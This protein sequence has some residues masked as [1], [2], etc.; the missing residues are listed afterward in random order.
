MKQFRN[1]STEIWKHLL[2]EGSIA[3]HST[4]LCHL[5]KLAHI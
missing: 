2:H 5:Q 1:L 3:E 4:L